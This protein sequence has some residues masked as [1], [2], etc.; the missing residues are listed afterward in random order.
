MKSTI[1]QGVE[2]EDL[3]R[4]AAAEAFCVAAHS[5]I[6][7][8]RRYTGEPYYTHCIRVAE[9]VRQADFWTVNMLIAALLHDVVEDTGIEAHLIYK[10]FGPEVGDYVVD[11]TDTAKLEDGNRAARKAINRKCIDNASPNSKTVKL[12][13]IIHNLEGIQTGFDPDFILLYAKEKRMDLS[14]LN[15]GD[16]GLYKTAQ[17]LCDKI[18]LSYTK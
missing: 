4:L 9:I 18:I 7:Q 17:S 10:M 13:D 16:T 15:Q 14:V 1:Y 12:A 3:V 8:T 2:G 5:A 11:L 6:K